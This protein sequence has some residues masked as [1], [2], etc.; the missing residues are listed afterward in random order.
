MLAHL[1]LVA[2]VAVAQVPDAATGVVWGVV[3]SENTGAPLRYALVEIVSQSLH[4]PIQAETD[5]NGYYV[6]R[7]VPPGRRVIRASHIDHASFE[8]AI[9]IEPGQQFY[10][11]LDL[12]LQPV[13][14]PVVNA[15]GSRSPPGASDTVSAR[16]SE[17]GTATVHVLEATPGMAELGLAEA[18]RDVPGQEPPDPSDVLFVRGGAADLK[19]V[20]L[21]GAPVY[22]PFHIGG[23]IHALDDEL[24]RSA[25]LYLGGAPARYDGGLSYV[26]DLETRSGRTRNAH[27]TMSVDMLAA[28][29]VLEGPLGPNISFLA[30]GRAVH[31]LGTEPFVGDPFP[32]TYGDAIS[33]IDL[34][35]GRDRIVSITG[36]WNRERV[37]LDSVGVVDNAA[38]WGNAAGSIRYRTEMFGSEA[39]FTVAAG[40][41][42]TQLPLGGHQPILTEALSQRTR[43]A[44]DLVRQLGPLRLHFGGSFDRLGFEQRAWPREQSEDSLLMRTHVAGDV[45][46]VYIDADILAGSRVRLR[47]GLRVDRFSLSPATRIAPRFSAT[48]LVTDRAALT[49]AAGRYRQYV[50]STGEQFP[51][52]ETT[53]P[54]KDGDQPELRVARASHLVLSLDQDLGDDMRLGI[55][56]FYKTYEGL[57]TE[58]GDEAEASGLDVWVRRGAGRLTGWFGYSLAWVWSTEEDPFTTNRIF[59]GRHLVSAGLSGPIIGSGEF[60]VRV[61]Y[62]AGLPYTAIPEPETTTPVFSVVGTEPAASLV[63]ANPLPDGPAEPDEPYLRVD[64]QL[65]R[66][67]AADLRGFAFEVTPYIKVMNA[68][69]RRDAL[70][71]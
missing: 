2:A 25:T 7:N 14:L 16:P 47:G 57:P 24:L 56:G 15:R 38:Q 69:D 1:A 27:A 63:T 32:Y 52:V 11:D 61:A 19:L 28:R 12:E 34:D 55:E 50:P 42:R 66:T 65:A 43:F 36:F 62:G 33:R 59:A 35:L 8:A 31:G 71:Y 30:G 17:L 26:M 67:F 3:R 39:L 54:D 20:L 18:A 53:V 29:T 58:N 13:L 9:V 49:L 46:G 68:L 10:L 70:F 21:N 51:F 45:A 40:E 22:A 6:L 60:D 48:V 64:A 44:A 5:R 37:L 23:L 41:F 4:A